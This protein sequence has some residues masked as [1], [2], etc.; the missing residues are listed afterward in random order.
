LWKHELRCAKT[1]TLLLQMRG[2]VAQ[3]I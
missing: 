2:L 3:M 1:F